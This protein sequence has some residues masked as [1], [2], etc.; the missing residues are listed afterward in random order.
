MKT[1]DFFRNTAPALWNFILTSV[2]PF[3]R[4][5]NPHCSNNRFPE[6]DQVY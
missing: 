4:A 6:A 5:L 1:S 3:W 2:G